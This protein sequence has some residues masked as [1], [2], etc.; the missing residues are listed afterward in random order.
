MCV[1]YNWHQVRNSLDLTIYCSSQLLSGTHAIWVSKKQ[2]VI[3]D[4]EKARDHNFD[5][6][7][8]FQLLHIYCLYNSTSTCRW[9]E[10]IATVVT[11]HLA[12][13]Y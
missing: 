7:C 2:T 5:G 10:S 12:I 13:L 11:R 4:N 8:S 3:L 9:P 1:L 6:K